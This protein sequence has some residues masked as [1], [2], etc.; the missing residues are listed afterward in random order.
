[1]LLLLDNFDSFTYNL[2]DYLGQLGLPHEVWRNDRP[3]SEVL[4]RDFKAIILS[5][6]PSRPAD[7]GIMPALIAACYRRLPMLGICLGHQALGEFFGASLTKAQKPMHG[8]ISRII[9]Q[10]RYFF[11]G[12]P[13]SFEVVRYHSLLL[14]ALPPCLEALAYTDD[15]ENALMAFKHRELPLAGIQFHPEAL[16]TEYGLS[17]LKNWLIHEN[18]LSFSQN[19]PVSK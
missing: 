7:A 4:A 11:E 8:K 14:E 13:P 18:I 2:S 5:P 16:L 19:L 12:L 15:A 10:N 3:L 9:C 6:G 1:V 17:I